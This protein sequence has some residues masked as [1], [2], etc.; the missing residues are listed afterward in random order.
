VSESARRPRRQRRGRAG[1]G[2]GTAGLASAP[3]LPPLGR[4]LCNGSRQGASRG[5]VRVPGTVTRGR[6]KFTRSRERRPRRGKNIRDA[7]TEFTG[8]RQGPRE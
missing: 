8:S 3:R 5:L 2:T 7:T 4:R 6:L 1:G